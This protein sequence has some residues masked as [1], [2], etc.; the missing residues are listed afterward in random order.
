M[1]LEKNSAK[2]VLEFFNFSL[3]FLSIELELLIDLP[4]EFQQNSIRDNNKL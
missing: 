4:E 1:I 2:N 3:R